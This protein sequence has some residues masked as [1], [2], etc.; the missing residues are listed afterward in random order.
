M[1]KSSANKS[2]TSRK[3]IQSYVVF[4]AGTAALFMD[5]LTG[6]DWVLMT[7]LVLGTYAY[8][9]IQE[10]RAKAIQEPSPRIPEN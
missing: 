4:A 2:R 5:K 7:G 10:H 9:N 8:G 6:T 1:T 3:L